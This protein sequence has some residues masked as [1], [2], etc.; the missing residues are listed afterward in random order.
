MSNITLT[1]LHQLHPHR[2]AKMARRHLAEICINVHAI[3]KHLKI[4]KKKSTTIVHSF[5]LYDYHVNKNMIV[6]KYLTCDL[7]INN[8]VFD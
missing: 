4:L 2:N 3:L 8:S 6:V 5:W 7:S 1:D